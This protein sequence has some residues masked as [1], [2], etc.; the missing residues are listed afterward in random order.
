LGGSGI[1][2]PRVVE[3]MKLRARGVAVR[4]P[5]IRH[6]MQSARLPCPTDCS[7]ARSCRRSLCFVC[8]LARSSSLAYTDFDQKTE[9]QKAF[10]FVP[11]PSFRLDSPNQTKTQ[12]ANKYKS[13]NIRLASKFWGQRACLVLC[14]FCSVLL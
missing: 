10:V 2:I 4:A 11:P 6:G 7:T 3:G 12:N 8:S 9:N 13:A 14:K 5:E 1:G